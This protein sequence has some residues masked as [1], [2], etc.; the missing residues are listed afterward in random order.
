MVLRNITA[1]LWLDLTLLGV[2]NLDEPILQLHCTTMLYNSQGVWSLGMGK[3]I[4]AVKL[5]VTKW[6][7]LV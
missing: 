5:H 1:P 7:L 2:E 4:T 3:N 6:V